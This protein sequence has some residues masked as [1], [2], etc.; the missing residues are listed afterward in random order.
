MIIRNRVWGSL[1]EMLNLKIENC[2]L[3]I[4]QVVWC[5]QIECVCLC[6]CA[7][8]RQRC[9]TGEPNW[10]RKSRLK[11]TLLF[12]GPV[13]HSAKYPKNIF[14]PKTTRYCE[15][16]QRETKSLSSVSFWMTIE[17]KK[18]SQARATYHECVCVWYA[19]SHLHI[20]TRTHKSNRGYDQFHW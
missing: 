10:N 7:W 16:E 14:W 17:Q 1:S 9:I 19:Y 3:A 5:G 11:L 20:N 13:R 6:L 4:R 8:Q 18:K 2:E 15:W 12:A